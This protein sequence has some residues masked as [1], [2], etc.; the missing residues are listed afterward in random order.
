M[1]VL[2]E[3][4]FPVNTGD[5][6]LPSVVEGSFGTHS[7]SMQ[8]GVIADRNDRSRKTMPVWWGG[9]ETLSVN[10][11]VLESEF[12]KCLLFTCASRG[13]SAFG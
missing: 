12:F 6:D 13:T 9:V 8:L 1:S 3:R 11:L 10:W 7:P 2:G 5:V 4:S